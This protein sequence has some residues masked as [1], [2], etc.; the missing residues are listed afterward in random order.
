M[1][2]TSVPKLPR[3]EQVA[4]IPRV[5]HQTFP[6]RILPIAF[7][8]NVRRLREL[9]PNWDYRFYDDDDIV[10]YIR[11]HYGEEIFAYFM[12]IDAR[13]GA[14]RADVFRYLLMYREGGVYLDIKSA[15]RGPLD[16]VLRSDDQ[17][18]LSYWRGS[19]FSGWGDYSELR[20]YGGREFQQWHIITAP[21]HPY[22]RSVL[23][24]V[25]QNIES[26]APLTW[27]VGRKGVMRVTGPVAYTRAI[28][29]V[30]SKYPHRLVN[31]QDELLLEY[32]TLSDGHHRSLFK[33]HYTFLREPVVLLEGRRRITWILLGPVYK[34]G[35]IPAWR[36]VAAIL[37]RINKVILFLGGKPIR[38]SE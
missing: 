37:R 8:E 13:Y 21:G 1:S 17:Y 35:V 34:Y 15:A 36:I 24:I 3:V 9:H 27:G 23:E 7:R 4:S 30:R 20:E 2:S 19:Q 18:V 26:Y 32:T 31:G 6:S 33:F 12:R 38:L 25:L 11:T 29:L 28:G 16:E 14:A 5:L 22:L 10:Q